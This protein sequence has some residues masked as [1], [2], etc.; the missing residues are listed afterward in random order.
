MIK[1]EI[2]S[3]YDIKQIIFKCCESEMY[4]IV[5]LPNYKRTYDQINQIENKLELFIGNWSCSYDLKMVFTTYRRMRA[6][7]SSW[8]GTRHIRGIQVK[9][10]IEEN[11]DDDVA[12]MWEVTRH[13]LGD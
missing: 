4:L 8:S 6:N 5:L 13:I 12:I 7:R 10:D 1:K 2:K 9:D 11:E 3:K